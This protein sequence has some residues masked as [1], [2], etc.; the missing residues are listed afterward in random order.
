MNMN[1]SGKPSQS[2]LTSTQSYEVGIGPSGRA[3]KTQSPNYM[4]TCKLYYPTIF[5]LSLTSTHLCRF[6][7]PASPAAGPEQLAIGAAGKL[8]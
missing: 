3:D 1:K 4:T 8:F 5:N 7:R 2:Q 6:A